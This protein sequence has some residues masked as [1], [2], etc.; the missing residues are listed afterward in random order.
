[1]CIESIEAGGRVLIKGT[2]KGRQLMCISQVCI[3][4]LRLAM[5]DLIYIYILFWVG[6]CERLHKVIN[7]RY[8]AIG[9]T[10]TLC[11]TKWYRI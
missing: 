1:M 3:T 11:P 2:L 7:L 4:N 10:I 5:Y 8:V 6:E 9:L